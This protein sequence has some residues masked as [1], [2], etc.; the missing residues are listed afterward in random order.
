MTYQWKKLGIVWFLC[1][2]TVVRIL[3][4]GQGT[5]DLCSLDTTE[6]KIK[7]EKNKVILEGL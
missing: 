7:P 3:K 5:D 4:Q 2:D 6:T 1:R